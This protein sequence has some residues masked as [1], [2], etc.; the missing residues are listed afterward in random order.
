MANS[1][2]NPDRLLGD[3]PPLSIDQAKKLVQYMANNKIDSYSKILTD[4]EFQIALLAC[5][6]DPSKYLKEAG[7][8]ETLN[9]TQLMSIKVVA[10]STIEEFNAPKSS[11]PIPPTCF[12]IN[13][14][15]K[16]ETARTAIDKY[17]Q[18]LALKGNQLTQPQ[19]QALATD[20]S[21]LVVANKT[22][23][24]N[25]TELELK[26]EALLKEIQEQDTTTPSLSKTSDKEIVPVSAPG[27]AIQRISKYHYKAGANTTVDDAITGLETEKAVLPATA[28]SPY[29]KEVEKGSP[30]LNLSFT[31]T[32]QSD[33]QQAQRTVFSKPTEVDGKLGVKTLLALQ[34]NRAIHVA[35]PD[36]ASIQTIW[37]KLQ[38]LGITK[39]DLSEKLKIELTKIN[40]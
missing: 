39:K 12:T 23:P 1:R 35:S 38:A 31:T 21:A 3:A 25:K 36:K 8:A 6:E 11:E 24:S 37:E 26:A 28:K 7:I 16:N 5:I 9:E 27:E 20:Y 34:L 29:I 14:L 15:S 4:K 17:Y 33:I 13:A 18:Y 2:F 10:A 32:K 30:L 19:Q 40:R 22:T